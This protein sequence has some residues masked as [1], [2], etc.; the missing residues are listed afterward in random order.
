[1]TIAQQA[2]DA[3]N[4]FGLVFHWVLRGAGVGKNPGRKAREFLKGAIKHG[5]TSIA[6]R[7]ERD[8]WFREEKIKNEHWDIDSARAMDLLAG[9]APEERPM[10]VQQRRDA[11]LWRR[12]Q[13]SGESG[14]TGGGSS[15]Y[16]RATSSRYMGNHPW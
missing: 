9:E 7:F 12:N 16:K 13:Y 8:H 15:T 10:T 2:V 6:D 11:N 4:E 14:N 5:F 1:M 3:K